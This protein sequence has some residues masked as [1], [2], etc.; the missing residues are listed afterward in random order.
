MK[1]NLILL[2]GLL[3][4]VS[5]FF[6]CKENDEPT[7]APEPTFPE[8]QTITAEAGDEITLSFSANYD[9]VATISE[10]TYTYFQLLS[11]ETKVNR[12]SGIAGEQT[13]K[14]AVAEDVVYEDAPVAEVTLTMDG[15]SQVIAKITYPI[16][17]RETAVYA[18]EVNT[19]GGF[20][21]AGAD[22]K[23]LYAYNTTAMTADD[24][25]VMEWGTERKNNDADDTFFAPVLVEANFDYTLAGPAWMTAAAAGVAGQTEYIIK[26]DLAQIPAE[27]ETAAI[28][29]LAGETAV[30]SFKVAI[31]GANDFVPQMALYSEAEYAFDGE[32]IEGI[33]G[34]M[35]AGQFV[36]VVCDATGATAEWLTVSEEAQ[37]DAVITTYNITATA[38]A[39]D[40]AAR[41]A[42][43]FYFAKNAAP[44]D[45]ASLFE[46]GE[47]KEE[48]AESLAVTVTQYSEPA[49]I[50]GTEVDLTCAT[51]S[52]VGADFNNTWFFDDLGV[53]IGSKYDLNYWGEWATYAHECTY[54]TASRPIASLT[55]YAF[56]DGGSLVEVTDGW[57]RAETFGAEENP[58]KFRVYCEDLSIIPEAAKNWQ[59]GEGEATILIEHTDGSYS[60]FYFHIGAGGA[61]GGDEITEVT[62]VDPMSAEMYGA[63]LVQLTEADTELYDPT[64]V[65]EMGNPIPQYH[66]TYTMAGTVLA[67][68]LPSYDFAYPQ[69]EWIM[70]EGSNTELY[71]GMMTEKAAI[72]ILN[73]YKGSM[74]A[75]RIVCEYAPANGGNE[76]DEPETIDW[77][78]VMGNY[79]FENWESPYH[80]TNTTLH[81]NRGFGYYSGL[82]GVYKANELV[83]G[84]DGDKW[85]GEPKDGQKY[86]ICYCYWNF[87]CFDIDSVEIN[88]ETM[89]PQEGTGCYALIN[90]IDRPGAID[91]ILE[92]YS[93]YNKNEGAFYVSFLLRSINDMNEDGSL[94]EGKT[95]REHTGKLHTRVDF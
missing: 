91:T 89:Q 69:A 19:W 87:I 84:G 61:S 41:T 8:L 83:N 49:T 11:G 95:D 3:L 75:V 24:A 82:K 10:D 12:L 66:L 32:A 27:S 67:L 23:L 74:A 63:T 34:S 5:T 57:V 64:A 1:K 62:F 2:C 36:K 73:F 77:D 78:Y 48:Y 4:S 85:L 46:N 50:E 94:K 47:V 76:D 72:G 21:S 38:T 9:W 68:S 52:E 39:N 79:T 26:A 70:Y 43:V 31:T 45:N 13:I 29:I 81:N 44:A 7:P 55:C 93:Y 42:Y 37:S 28:E 71:I 60:A 88:P 15:K 56:N 6:A 86:A 14:V 22:G 25:V 80:L 16:T 30:A 33:D 51:F 35:L 90:M 58:V 20:K 65:D 53:T 92:N 40:G 59:T 54:F 18:P 17:V